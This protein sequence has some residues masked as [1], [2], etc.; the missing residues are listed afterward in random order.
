[1]QD[2]ENHG[3]DRIRIA[4]VDDHPLF[5]EGVAAI[6][7][8]NPR[9]EVVAQGS[10]AEQ[11]IRI[12]HDLLPDILL[13]DV[14]MPGDGMEAMRRIAQQCPYVKI[15]MLTASEDEQHVSTALEAGA[16]GYVLKGIGAQ[17]L[18]STLKAVFA[19]ESYVTPQLAAR[20]LSL[21]RKKPA[22]DGPDAQLPVLTPREEEILDRVAGGRTNKEIARDL[23]ISE[24]TVKHYMTNIMHKLQVRNR[25]EAAL[26]ARRKVP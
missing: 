14:A 5:R 4:V 6:L 1:M 7:A 20:L 21:M 22:S 26:M 15:V 10:S 8:Q 11:A 23:G 17:D 24:K 3:E 19:G 25:V 12:A 16:R 18:L 2:A 13:L 9:F